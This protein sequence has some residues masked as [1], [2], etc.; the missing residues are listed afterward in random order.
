MFLHKN[1]RGVRDEELEKISG[2]E[3]TI[4][5][6]TTGFIGGNK[7]RDGALEMAIKSLKSSANDKD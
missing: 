3:G 4:F 2:I 1:W 7:T 5:C 6:H